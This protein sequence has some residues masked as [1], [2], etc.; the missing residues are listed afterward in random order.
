MLWL[1]FT[2]DGKTLLSSSRDET[3]K[4]WDAR[5]GKLLRTLTE[6]AGDVYGVVYSPDERLLATC[7]QDK[8]IRLWNAQSFDVLRVLTGHTDII[9]AVAFSPDQKS[10]VSASVDTTVRLWDVATGELKH[11]LKGHTKRVKSV[12]YG[13]NGDWIATAASDRTIRIWDPKTGGELKVL[14]GH[15]GDLETLA[16][17]P[18]G[19]LLASSS[20]DTTLRLWDTSTWQTVRTLQGHTAEVNFVAF[21]RDG[22]TLGSGAVDKTIRL[23]DVCT[24]SL[25]QSFPGHTGYVESLIFSPDG[26]VLATG[27]G[28][29]DSSIRFWDI[30]KINNRKGAAPTESK[31]V[32]AVSGRPYFP[33]AEG[34]WAPIAPP[35]A[36]W[37]EQKLNEALEF[38]GKNKS[39]GVVVLHHGRILAERHWE[40]DLVKGNYARVVRGRDPAGHVIEDTASIQKSVAALLVGLARHDGFLN[41]EDP[42]QKYLG[43]GWS[44]ASPAQENQITVRHLLTMTSGLTEELGFEAPPGTV[45]RY[46]DPVYQRILRV[47]ETAM[48]KPVD[49]LTRTR[50]AER[51]GIRSSGWV[52]RPAATAGNGNPIGYATTARDLAR[53]GL[54]ILAEG[55]WNGET[56]I[57]D[58]EFLRA[59]QTPSQ[60]LN[61][62]Y[63]YFWWLN[64]QTRYIDTATRRRDGPWIERGPRDLVAA[65]GA[66]DRR[67]YVVRSLNL[68]VV[69]LGDA[70]GS[71]T[72]DQD[73]WGLLMAAAPAERAD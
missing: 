34:E 69:R 25:L 45:W 50:L 59:M 30:S 13:L 3:V 17:S 44:K 29:G 32:K 62:S 24:G 60:E 61:P 70:T 47:L 8:T 12:V 15:T 46:N 16:L 71:P 48:K 2:R 41:L 57:P 36:G 65:F 43:G 6:H 68:V 20:G 31:T 11:T 14:E 23:W 18:D 55:Q 39:S 73:F 1:D 64:G 42:V 49:E 21:S 63:G 67:L 22:R 5:S 9:R 35:A 10:L 58:Q 28:G 51:I 53:L 56:V 40:L 4:V 52:R 33:P 72:F 27:G 37:N 38:A 54:L 19:Q 26:N 7:S 66:S